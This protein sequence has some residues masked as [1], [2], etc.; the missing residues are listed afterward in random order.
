MRSSTAAKRWAKSDS[1]GG[2]PLFYGSTASVATENILNPVDSRRT[3]LIKLATA[4]TSAVVS[5]L[6]AHTE[7]REHHVHEMVEQA[8]PAIPVEPSYFSQ[9][10][11]DIVSRLVDLIIPRTDTPGAIDAGVPH[12][13]DRQV[14]AKPELQERF[15]DGLS[16]LAEQARTLNGSSF[17]ALTERQQ[18]A[19]LQ[20]L[21]SDPDTAKSGFFKTVKDLT[22]DTYYRTEGGLVKELG[23]HGNTFNASFPGCTHPEHWP[24]SESAQERAQ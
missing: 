4:A 11:Y 13:I 24:S 17:T 10:D 16:Y 15:K 7:E 9:A 1:S 21:S 6:L 22:V 18:V 8:T 20:A 3:A 14:G 23:Y 2:K 5:P 12:W 19:I